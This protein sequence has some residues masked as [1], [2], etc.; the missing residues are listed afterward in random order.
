[1]IGGNI[2]GQTRVASLAIYDDVQ[3]M[4]YHSANGYA[5]ILLLLSFSILLTVYLVNHHFSKTNPLP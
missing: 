5:L 2:P 4:N 1:M 3:S